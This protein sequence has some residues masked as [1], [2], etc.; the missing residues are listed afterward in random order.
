MRSEQ[1]LIGLILNFNFCRPFEAPSYFC[2]Y[3]FRKTPLIFLRLTS[4]ANSGAL[5]HVCA[6]TNYSR[7]PQR[8]AHKHSRQ[9]RALENPFDFQ[10]LSPLR[11]SS[12]ISA[13]TSSA[14]SSNNLEA[15]KGRYVE[16]HV[17]ITSA[18]FRA[19]RHLTAFIVWCRLAL[20]W[21]QSDAPSALNSQTYRESCEVTRKHVEH[22]LTQ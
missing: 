15:L 9:E 1:Y 21:L 13:T 4:S 5:I 17:S 19:C 20:P 6:I 11:G 22:A 18:P 7:S 12:H 2:N 10:L 8:A 14:N 3:F 16:G